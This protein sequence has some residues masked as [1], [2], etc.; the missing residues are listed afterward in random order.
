M[1]DSSRIDPQDLAALASFRAR[2]RALP[3]LPPSA[4]RATAEQGVIAAYEAAGLERPRQIVWCR[5]PMEIERS[6]RTN[7]IAWS[8]GD[9]VKTAVVDEVLRSVGE[10]LRAVVPIDLA[11][12]VARAMAAPPNAERSVGDAVSD[13]VRAVRWP[14][15]T[16]LAGAARRLKRIP[17]VPYTLFEQAS[18]GQ[19]Q[20]RDVL[21][22]YEF[23]NERCGPLPETIKLR[24]LWSM[25]PNVGWVVPHRHVCWMSDRCI[26]LAVDDSGRLH[27]GTGP[28]L[29]FADGWKLY[30]W[31]G[32]TVPEWL[33]ERRAEITVPAIN[34]MHDPIV[35]RCMIELMT[36]E[37]FVRAGGAQS[38]ASDR[39]GTLWQARWGIDVWHA[40]EV[41]N[42]TPE[43]DGTSKHY[44][45]Q[46]PP[47]VRSPIDAVA[48]TYGMNAQRYAALKL[49][50]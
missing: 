45:L 16:I 47:E 28:A 21:G 24:G 33:I 10:S 43:P 39:T 35:R 42:G 30:A 3:T 23:L 27:S 7:W 2:W 49:R 31:K 11:R 36:P 38:I 12:G 18:W 44:Y 26:D 34:G 1:S 13:A 5:S 6:R 14:I 15:R 8:P 17:V 40:V 32:I 48:W 4:A 19:L 20:F 46:V 25:A 41:V 29:S 22:T 9:N 37:R 50:T